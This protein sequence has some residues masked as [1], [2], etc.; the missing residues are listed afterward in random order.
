ML[1]K[2]K[3]VPTGTTKSRPQR[4]YDYRQG[5]E[6]AVGAPRAY[7]PREGGPPLLFLTDIRMTILVHL[8][9]A[10]TPIRCCWLWKHLGKSCK[11]ALY[12]LIETGL[13]VKW[14]ASGATY[15]ALDPAH[16]AA[17]EIGVLLLQVARL[18]KGFKPIPYDADTVI[19]HVPV[20]R[21]RRRDV[22]LTF[23]DPTRTMSLLLIHILG[24]P[25][26]TD[27]ER[28]VR[29]TERSTVR[30][31]FDMYAAFR[32]LNRTQ[33]IR[34][35]KRAYGYSFND[36]HPLVPYIKEV[37]AALDR[38]MP[39]WRSTAE[40]QRVEPLPT[41]RGTKKGGFKPNRRRW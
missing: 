2:L 22:R 40:R 15:I 39:M 12:P 28:C 5:I 34:S 10:P 31:L 19:Q 7:Q 9:L 16:P 32:L 33:V 1:P 37:L 20:R 36:D 41:K 38:A 13:V 21:S 3:I 17:H 11:T 18:Y 23:G 25:I 27:V 8:A 4:N 6:Y 14:R 24:E 26:S 35:K 30:G 29:Y